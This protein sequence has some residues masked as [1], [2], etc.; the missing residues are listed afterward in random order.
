MRSVQRQPEYEMPKCEVIFERVL[1]LILIA[2]L[3][4]LLS[5]CAN[6]IPFKKAV[7]VP[8]EAVDPESVRDS[9]EAS[10]PQSF[11]LISSTVFKY[12]MHSFAAIGVT[13]IDTRKKEFTLA[14]INPMGVKLFELAGDEQGVDCRFAMKEFTQKGDFAKMVANDI[15]SIYFDRIP[16]KNAEVVKKNKKIIF[17]QPV[18]GGT[19]EYLFGGTGN[20]LIEKRFIK[21]GRKIWS[22][23]YFEYISKKGKLHPAG[24]ILKNYIYRYKLVIRAKG[25]Q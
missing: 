5:G 15:R 1:R 10:L 19:M 17:F 22:V 13:G 12:K 25:N 18:N 24:I 4:L 8:V 21:K 23:F 2:G 11:Q 9:F 14:C 6:K 3:I 7:L 20:L 16:D